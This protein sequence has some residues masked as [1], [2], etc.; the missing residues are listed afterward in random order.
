MFQKKIQVSRGQE[1]M[2]MI[3]FIAFVVFVLLFSSIFTQKAEAYL[4]PGTGSYIFQILI[5]GIVGG[6]FVIKQ[7]WNKITA[8][9]KTLF[10]TKKTLD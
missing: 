7:F 9:F 10:S 1:I 5:A 3:L 2:R 8:F 6:I 4:D